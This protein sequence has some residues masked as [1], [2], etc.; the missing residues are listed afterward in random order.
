[1]E[2]KTVVYG[3]VN[4]NKSPHGGKVNKATANANTSNAKPAAQAARDLGYTVNISDEA[5]ALAAANGTATQK[6]PQAPPTTAAPPNTGA[7]G[8]GQG[9][10]TT[11]SQPSTALAASP[12]GN[13]NRAANPSAVRRLWNETNHAGEALITLIRSMLD[14][15]GNWASVAGGTN[16]S[17]ADRLQAQQMI[18]EDGFFGVRQTTDRIMN[19][20]KA[21]IGED[22]S[23]EQIE[24]MRA[25]VQKGFD[26]VAQMFGG[27][28]N[29][30]QVSR[31]THAAIMQAFDDWAARSR[32]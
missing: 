16:V 28:N 29:L 21:M 27:F 4:Q 25:A 22:A 14:G 15:Q 1:M 11:E 18:S 9:E 13:V 17:G 10:S 8:G 2:L 26:Q 23:E 24:S 7:S 5:K 3:N 6:P 31:D 20:A 19:F 30:P 12:P 32:G